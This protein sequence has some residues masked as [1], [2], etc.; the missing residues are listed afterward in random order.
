MYNYFNVGS[1]FYLTELI[2]PNT[3]LTMSEI[4]SDNS[5][6]CVVPFNIGKRHLMINVPKLWNDLHFNIT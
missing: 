5:F 3:F 2:I 1:A 4:C 6:T